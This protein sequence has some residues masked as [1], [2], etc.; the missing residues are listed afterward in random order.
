MKGYS[1]LAAAV[2]TAAGVGAAGTAIAAEQMGVS[3]N[4]IVI[5][6]IQ[7]L[8]GPLAGFGKALRYGMQMR[9]DEVGF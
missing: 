7:D 8:S 9:V 6:T 3:K 5:G 1:K 2:L 4:E